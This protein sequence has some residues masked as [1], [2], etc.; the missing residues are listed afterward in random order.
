[1]IAVSGQ[2][3]I[4]DFRSEEQLDSDSSEEGEP[5]NTEGGNDSSPD[6][7]ST[8]KCGV[9]VWSGSE[10]THRT[11]SSDMSSSEDEAV[12]E[13]SHQCEK[14]LTTGC[15]KDFQWIR[16]SS[17]KVDDRSMARGDVLCQESGTADSKSST[18]SINAIGLDDVPEREYQSRSAPAG[19]PPRSDGKHS[20]SA[21]EDTTRH[22]GPGESPPGGGGDTSKLPSQC[23]EPRDRRRH[24]SGGRLQ[25]DQRSRSTVLSHSPR[26]R[27]PT[28]SAHAHHW[29]SPGPCCCCE[30]YRCYGSA[31][32]LD[33]AGDLSRCCGRRAVTPCCQCEQHAY[34][35]RHAS[36]PPGELEE[37]LRR[38]ESDKDSLQLQVAVLNDQIDAQADKIGDLEKMLEEK[39]K[40]LTNTEDVLQREMLA[41]SS[42]E[43]QKLELLSALS[44]LK[45]Q[46][47]TTERDNLDLREKLAEERRRNKPPIAPRASLGAASTPLGNQ[48]SVQL[49]T[50]SPSPSPVSSHSDSSPRRLMGQPSPGED[51]QQSQTPPTNFRHYGSLPRYRAANGSAVL[52][53]PAEGSSPVMAGS[54]VPRKGV[55]FGKGHSSFLPFHLQ[56]QQQHHQYHLQQQHHLQY[57]QHHFVHHQVVLQRRV[58]A[59]KSY[60][61]P[62]LAETEKVMMIED[63][64]SVPPEDD[65]HSATANNISPSSQ[66]G[67]QLQFNKNKGIKKIFGRIKR[68]G[69]GNL[70]DLTGEGEF[71]RGGVRA[72]AGPRLG[73]SIQPPPKQLPNLPFA[74]WDSDAVSQW[75]V[76]LGLEC[77][78]GDAKRW[79]KSGAQLLAASSQEIDKELGIKNGLHRKKLQLA[80]LARQESVASLDPHLG[81]AGRLDTAWVLRWLD[82]VGLPQHKEAF[83]AARVDGRLL[84]RLALDDLAA[85][86]V[87]SHLHVASVRRGIQVLRDHMF[88]GDCLKRRS[89]PD[90]PPHP[91]PSEVATWTNHRVMEW[92]RVVDLAEYAPN[93]RG[94]GV[95]GGLM[96]HE[97]RFTADLLASLLSIPPGKTLLRRHL[98]T[99]FKELLGRDCIQAKRDAE[100]TL[101]Y[102]PL[103]AT[104]K[105]KLVKK[106]QFTLKRKKSKS[107]LDFGDLVCPLDPSKTGEAT[108]GDGMIQNTSPRADLDVFHENN[109]QRKSPDL[110]TDNTLPGTGRTSNL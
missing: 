38:L 13:S 60:S 9:A 23:L 93:L 99:H 84:H 22:R 57:P 3:S 44:E 10:S 55:A 72:T 75:F 6:D 35:W 66:A 27:S 52:A 17:A 89:L 14:D 94:S 54:G 102:V 64:S 110:Q 16:N 31:G 25:R 58:G 63:R 92:L 40:Q 28:R 65:E 12:H 87:A 1:M 83:L 26:Y 43:T 82:D 45:L 50:T 86:H 96:I 91:S 78:A 19:R 71:R 107:E 42:L 74:D 51:G 15:T 81:P 49:L 20:A 53:G 76:E 37:R 33:S 67:Q 69:S 18:G 98:N 85:L 62:N 79:V 39:R 5:V 104:T 56:Q 47:A 21:A 46:Q 73:W 41:R 97:P 34:T 8:L 90:D 70:E 59:D 106:T 7:E 36:K 4:E 61:T 95:H 68:S 2:I 101:G 32:R 48:V 11:S 24:H 105:I 30:P 100:T 88:D 109:V 77:Y 108:H 103:S 29:S 80:L